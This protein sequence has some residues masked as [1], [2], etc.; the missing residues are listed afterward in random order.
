MSVIQELGRLETEDLVQ[1]LMVLRKDTHD[2]VLAQSD[3]S[4]SSVIAEELTEWFRV[5]LLSQ[6]SELGFQ[7]CPWQVT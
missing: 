1:N 2:T 4:L 7:S 5:A 6:P 3:M